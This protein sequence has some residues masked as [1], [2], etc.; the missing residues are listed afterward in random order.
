M[1]FNIEV[2]FR[3]VILLPDVM[4]EISMLI[5]KSK[6]T[7]Y[8]GISIKSLVGYR[9][10]H[11]LHTKY[12]GISIKSLVGYRK[13]HSLHTKYGGISIVTSRLS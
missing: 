4:I 11:S 8:G 9:K 12:G 5:L 10:M 7:R 3:E 2:I 13:M 6:H 1:K